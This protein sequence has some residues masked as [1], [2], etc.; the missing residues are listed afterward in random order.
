MFNR[1]LGALMILLGAFV[2]FVAAKSTTPEGHPLNVEWL[3]SILGLLMIEVGI[4]VMFFS[5]EE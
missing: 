4:F 3:I 1:I 2:V 5:K